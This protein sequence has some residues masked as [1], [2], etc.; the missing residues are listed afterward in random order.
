MVN[1]NENY[2][3]FVAKSSR[4]EDILKKNKEELGK[5]KAEF[6]SYFTSDKHTAILFKKYGEGIQKVLDTLVASQIID[7]ICER[8]EL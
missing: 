5:V 2:I 6:A 8:S 7:L 1:L 4:A 3:N